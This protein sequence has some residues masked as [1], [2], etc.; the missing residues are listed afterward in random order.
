[1]RA[2]TTAPATGVIRIFSE[3]VRQVVIEGYA[4]ENDA[5]YTDGSLALAA[6]AYIVASYES[7][8]VPV[9]LDSADPDLNP[10][11]LWP[12]DHMWKP[13]GDPIRNLEK[14]GAL[15]AAEIDRLVEARRNG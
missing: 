8:W 13:S 9:A 12:W 11:D 1:M 10:Q 14:A 5:A 15:I 3:R 6:M 4:P 2:E 7:G